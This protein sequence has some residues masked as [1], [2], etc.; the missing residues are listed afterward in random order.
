ML[1]PP[2]ARVIP[3]LP[4]LSV[5]SVI[6]A[7]W[8]VVAVVAGMQAV[9]L[10]RHDGR[11]DMLGA[12]ATRVSIIPL[13]AIATPFILRSARWLPVTGPDRRVDHVSLLGHLGLGSRFVVMAN[14]VIPMPIFWAPRATGGGLDAL[15]QSTLQGVAEYYPPAMVVYGVIV[16]AGHLVRRQTLTT[17]SE[18]PAA[19]PLPEEINQ[20]ASA[21]P[22]DTTRADATLAATSLPSVETSAEASVASANG[23]LTVR[24]WNRVHLVRTEDIDWIEAQD[25]YVVVHAVSRSYKGR[26]RISDVEVQ[27]DPRQFVRIHRR[28][29]VNIDRVKELQPWFGGDYIIALRDGKK[30]R[31]SRNFREDFQGRMLGE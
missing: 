19:S 1:T 29:I 18:L 5:P 11:A 13:W 30:L 28:F 4:R 27:L 31:L 3:L 15:M 2:D 8:S 22:A 14:V 23:H 12:I 24:Q 17:V 16:A 7:V 10:V 6:V 9:A 25:N 20:P 26:E 21:P